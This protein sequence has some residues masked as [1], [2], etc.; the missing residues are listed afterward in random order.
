MSDTKEKLNS[1]IHAGRR[2]KL[3]ERFLN[4]G[5]DTFN[6]CEVLEFALGF[7]IPRQDTNPAAHSLIE[8][9]GSLQAIVDAEPTVLTQAYGI[10]EQAGIFLHFLNEL[11]IYLA[12]HRATKV[13]ITTPE[14]A[15]KYLKPLMCS[16]SVEEFIVVCLDT[17]GNV[18]KIHN[19]TNKELDMVHVNV[20]EI[21]SVVTSCKTAQVVIA[22]NHLNENPEPSLS[23]IKLTRRLWLTSDNLGLKFLEHV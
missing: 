14:D 11:S 12:K 20:R 7:C 22:H 15:I 19:T 8:K 2:K 6:E 9:F 1:Q 4:N 23:D 10:G 18:I 16:Y 3:R 17:A 21:I 13:K 5:L